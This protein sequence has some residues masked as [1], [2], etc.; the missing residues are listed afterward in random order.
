MTAERTIQAGRGGSRAD[1]LFEGPGGQVIEFDWKTRGASALS[2]R[3][4]QQMARHAT[5]IG[6]NMGGTV[7]RQESR[8]W[9]DY[10]RPLMPG[11]NWPR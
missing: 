2:S 1:L 5:Q 4:E 11:V 10:V 9:I 3:T 7:T 6:A 8:S